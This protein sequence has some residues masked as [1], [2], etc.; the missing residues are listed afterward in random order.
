MDARFDAVDARFDALALDELRARVTGLSE[1]LDHLAG[2]MLARLAGVEGGLYDLSEK[3]NALSEDMRQRF[4]V[5]GERLGDI[6]RR[7]AA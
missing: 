2:G 6:D 5:V 4:R 3:V 1:R 7:L